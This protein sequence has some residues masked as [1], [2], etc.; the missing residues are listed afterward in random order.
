MFNQLFS[1]SDAL[2]RQLSAPLVEERRRYLAQCAAVSGRRTQ[3]LSALAVIEPAT[4]L[5]FHWYSR[6][7]A[8]KYSH[9][10]VPNKGVCAFETACSSNP[11]S[12][13]R[14]DKLVVAA[15]AGLA[16]CHVETDR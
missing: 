1:R 4:L 12:K 10:N 6:H 16:F 11:S 7:P 2:T 5:P 15:L 9:R 8:Q 3:T 14:S 13:A